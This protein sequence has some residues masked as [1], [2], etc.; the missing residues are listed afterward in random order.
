M[1][2]LREQPELLDSQR[3]WR[4]ID[5]SA[6]FLDVHAVHRLAD[7]IDLPRRHGYFDNRPAAEDFHVAVRALWLMTK[8]GRPRVVVWVRDTDGSG[9]RRQ[10]W[11]DA[12][13]HAGQEFEA[14]LAGFPHEC[15]EAW[16]LAAWLPT[17]ETDRQRLDQ[18]RSQLGF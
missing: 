13:E 8:V 16:L 6:T 9:Q 15:M 4:G 3:R 1:E 11:Q 10:G 17:S 2:W 14:A 18:A 5:E 12:S 7:E